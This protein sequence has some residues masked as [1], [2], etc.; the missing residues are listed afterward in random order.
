[1][2]VHMDG[3][4]VLKAL[5]KI[6]FLISDGTPFPGDRFVKDALEYAQTFVKSAVQETQ[7]ALRYV[8]LRGGGDPP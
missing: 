6:I 7:V 5:L 1:M 3:C 8:N 2:K 4:E